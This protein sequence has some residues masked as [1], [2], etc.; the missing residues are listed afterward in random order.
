MVIKHQW[1]Q[2]TIFPRLPGQI[3][4]EQKLG[5]IML[6][7]YSIQYNLHDNIRAL[8]APLPILIKMIYFQIKRNNKIRMYR[9]GFRSVRTFGVTRRVRNNEGAIPG[10]IDYRRPRGKVWNEEAEIPE[11]RVEWDRRDKMK[12]R[13][14]KTIHREGQWQAYLGDKPTD[15]WAP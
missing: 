4:P 13:D 11:Y 6:L 2:M 8:R 9:I 7:L 10:D 14:A 15:E 5:Q 1:S 3:R 12:Q